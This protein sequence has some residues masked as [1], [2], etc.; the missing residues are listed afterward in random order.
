MAFLASES[1]SEKS[2][3]VRHGTKWSAVLA[4][5]NATPLC[6][7]ADYEHLHSPFRIFQA[8]SDKA[9]VIPG[10]AI[11]GDGGMVKACI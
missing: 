2:F 9:S 3:V 1:Y 5:W 4:H 6:F 10:Q 11:H 8:S 7:V